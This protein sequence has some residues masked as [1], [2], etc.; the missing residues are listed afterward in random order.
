MSP[1]LGNIKL[2]PSRE[3]TNAN[4]IV[5]GLIRSVIEHANHYA[6][7]SVHLE[8]YTDADVKHFVNNMTLNY[9]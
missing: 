5:F 1:P 3:A 7:D 4:F 2:I 9:E 8:R 6:T